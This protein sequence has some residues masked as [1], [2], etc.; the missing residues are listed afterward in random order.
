MNDSENLSSVSSK[1]DIYSPDSVENFKGLTQMDFST[2]NGEDS[3]SSEI[4]VAKDLGELEDLTT[5][6][7]EDE[8]LT[9][10]ENS[11]KKKKVRSKNKHRDS[12]KKIEL[13][14]SRYSGISLADAGE[15]R[16]MVI[17]VGEIRKQNWDSWLNLITQNWRIKSSDFLPHIQG[18]IPNYYSGKNS[19]ESEVR[20]HYSLDN[21]DEN[22]ELHTFQ[23]ERQIL[24]VIGIVDCSLS[25]DLS[26]SYSDFH[27]ILSNNTTAVGFKCFGFDY[28]LDVNSQ[29][30]QGI[31]VVSKFE[32]NIPGFVKSQ[33]HE[34]SGVL[35]S[36]LSLMADSIEIQTSKNQPRNQ[37]DSNFDNLPIYEAGLI[38]KS[39]RVVAEM[40]KNFD[41]DHPPFI[42][43]IA[44]SSQAHFDS[45]SLEFEDISS[46][47]SPSIDSSSSYEKR[48]FSVSDA[49]QG[50]IKK[51]EGDL[52]LMAGRITEAIASYRTS[53]ELSY[54]N[55]D[56][57]WQGC[58][59]EG[60]AS[61]LFILSERKGERSFLVALAMCPPDTSV[62]NTIAKEQSYNSNGNT[63]L[64]NPSEENNPNKNYHDP[65][66]QFIGQ[67]GIFGLI[68]E[69]AYRFTEVITLYEKSNNFS[70]LL[71][72][73]ACLRR[74]I[75]QLLIDKSSS[76]PELEL[77]ISRILSRD[78][79]SRIYDDT[80]Q[81]NS[82][83]ELKSNIGYNGSEVAAWIQRGWTQSIMSL[84]L[85]DLM[86]LS[87]TIST[88][89]HNA[90]YNR[91]QAFFL[92]Q[93]LL[94]VQP[95]LLK[96]PENIGASN[97]ITFYNKVDVET[98][99]QIVQC[100][101]LVS[102]LYQVGNSDF[103]IKNSVIIQQWAF[104]LNN[105]P[106]TKRI[107]KSERT[108]MMKSGWYHLKSDVLRECVAIAESIPSYPHAIS[109]SFRLLSC[110]NSLEHRLVDL[111]NMESDQDQ[112]QENI[113]NEIERLHHERDN[114]I[115][116][117]RRIINIYHQKFHFDPNDHLKKSQIITSKNLPILISG[118]EK[119]AKAGLAISK[120]VPRVIGRDSLVVGDVFDNLLQS[121]QPN[122]NL[123]NSN[124][125]IG[126]KI[127]INSSGGSTTPF[128]YDP[129]NKSSGTNRQTESSVVIESGV[130]SQFLVT[131]FNPFLHP[132]QLSNVQLLVYP[133]TKV[134]DGRV[135]IYD[136]EEDYFSS[137]SPKFFSNTGII[138]GFQS[139]SI[140]KS[141]LTTLILPPNSLHTVAL[142]LVP[143]KTGPAFIVGIQ[144]SIFE[145]I[146][147]SCLLPQLSVDDAKKR[148]R[149][150]QVR[151]KLVKDLTNLQLKSEYSSSK[152]IALT[153]PDSGFVVPIDIIPSQ[154]KLDVSFQGLENNP[155][156]SSFHELNEGENI[157]F[158][159]ILQNNGHVPIYFNILFDPL[160]EDFVPKY[161]GASNEEIQQSTDSSNQDRKKN[162][163]IS[164]SLIKS[165]FKPLSDSTLP[166]KI[167]AGRFVKLDYKIIGYSS[168]YGAIL[169]I[170]YGS[171]LNSH[172]TPNTEKTLEKELGTTKSNDFDSGDDF[173]LRE[174]KHKIEV[175]VKKLIVPS[176]NST[177]TI[178]PIP[179]GVQFSDSISP[180]NACINY[181]A[182]NIVEQVVKSI[183][184]LQ[185]STS[186]SIHSSDTSSKSNHILRLDNF[187]LSKY[188]S[189]YFCLASFDVC[190]SSPFSTELIFEINLSIPASDI[191]HTET[192]SLYINNVENLIVKI[193]ISVP[194][195]KD[196][197]RI[198][199][200]ISRQKESID[201]LRF[202]IPGLDIE[203]N[204]SSSPFNWDRELELSFSTLPKLH[205]LVSSINTSAYGVSD[206]HKSNFSKNSK[207]TIE[208]NLDSKEV[209]KKG[210]TE[211]KSLSNDINIK[212]SPNEIKYSIQYIVPQGP[213][214]KDSQKMEM[215]RL[216]YF[217][218]YLHNS[219][220]IR[221]HKPD[222]GKSGFI[223]PRPF[224]DIRKSDLYSLI[225][226]SFEIQ[227]SAEYSSHLSS[228][229]DCNIAEVPNS[230]NST[231]K[232]CPQYL[233][234]EA[235][236][237]KEPVFSQI[238]ISF[239]SFQCKSESNVYLCI[240][241]KNNF[242][243]SIQSK[244]SLNMIY[245]KSSYGDIPI[246]QP[247]SSDSDIYQPS[248]T[249]L[250]KDNPEMEIHN[251][252]ESSALSYNHLYDNFIHYGVTNYSCN[253]HQNFQKNYIQEAKSRVAA[254]VFKAAISNVPLFQSANSPALENFDLGP[255]L[256]KTS[257]NVSKDSSILKSSPK[258]SSDLLTHEDPHLNNQSY[259]IEKGGCV[260]SKNKS[261]TF[262]SPYNPKPRSNN[263]S[264]SPNSLGIS[265][266]RSARLSLPSKRN[267]TISP[268][269]SS[270]LTISS[271]SRSSSLRS[272]SFKR[273]EP[274]ISETLKEEDYTKKLNSI[275][276]NI[277]SS[278]FSE[279]G[280][281]IPQV[282]FNP[283]TDYQLPSLASHGSQRILKIPIF[284]SSK[285][286]YVFEYE[287][288]VS[289]V[290]KD[291]SY[292]RNSKNLSLKND[293]PSSSGKLV[294]NNVSASFL[295]TS[296]NSD[297]VKNVP[298]IHESFKGT[299]T[300]YSI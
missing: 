246:L 79:I 85:R 64:Q 208:D 44:Q 175:R 144:C 109:G 90:K 244:L 241:L 287:I 212:S 139:N 95:L 2:R 74:A 97:N 207:P 214:L 206:F 194:G 292:L 82:S 295:S 249:F 8:S 51:L 153:K 62:T 235:F 156:S 3:K 251:I 275:S 197:H 264:Q 17:G 184:H 277:Y 80:L 70:P 60:Y 21:K 190:N 27:D 250:R 129:E 36:A 164:N 1:N 229:F 81:K 232:D 6:K 285:G 121:I 182:A 140:A 239:D 104:W 247:Y 261:F 222:L 163:K 237:N 216:Y 189:K 154:P 186:F 226:D 111:L 67:N 53:I 101:G 119:N 195:N 148:M 65:S 299:F 20:L 72:S 134:S 282:L 200:P 92:R 149:F 142:D 274:Q 199:I 203:A 55:E 162:I 185:S 145:H 118:L 34:F 293:H 169:K 270:T 256:N 297:E 138:Q 141:P 254:R 225:L 204:E 289:P 49:N 224:L 88:L 86:N 223:D 294:E 188:I 286:K 240:R 167:S 278:K 12:E 267:S 56:Y 245:P 243:D 48:S 105:K 266:T 43:S 58:A 196:S 91:K 171:S 5:Q 73:E 191:Q 265:G 32:K 127:I 16:V 18:N 117:L 130:I 155:N 106:W 107:I 57:T 280:L 135:P 31:N 108:G 13:G 170:V 84:K 288:K 116:Y 24:G 300:L 279:C 4:S 47:R 180:S 248:D 198:F 40:A 276:N 131:F 168:S 93:F 69:I 122:I 68:K 296:K 29:N 152:I 63:S 178:I 231:S 202:P 147:I 161:N 26:K 54:S 252:D 166:P 215:R 110:L 71:H 98:K 114:L 271:L 268:R 41:G 42:P 181:S 15:I 159:V 259:Q 123:N 132:L 174:Y 14:L 253:T 11:A 120:L 298:L 258:F 173:F 33:I 179:I 284:I 220:R 103:K 205:N 7:L 192:Q 228:S 234:D 19:L 269:K 37:D 260:F 219:I 272:T 176:L 9:Y 61:S 46:R 30:I 177:C 233:N 160:P 96:N 25:Q 99:K 230:A 45:S 133:S 75:L 255:N 23:T 146:S 238:P 35:V 281:S 151:K 83:L 183:E 112:Y 77:N 211:M 158:S 94:L 262:R 59:L 227:T 126:K 137:E 273:T 210:L 257:H 87:A 78:P 76:G 102:E 113:S 187:R 209:D 193:N 201:M 66:L 143:F 115:Q 100:L 38:G 157:S 172:I 242:Y 22:D 39:A 217:Q 10:G 263:G 28:P 128:L 213:R 50:R 125:S 236:L 52:L 89:F 291:G 283:I 221:Y 124:R 150:Q 136:Y 290:Q 218:K 165:V